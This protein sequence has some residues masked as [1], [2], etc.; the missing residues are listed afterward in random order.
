MTRTSTRPDRVALVLIYPCGKAQKP[1]FSSP[2][3]IPDRSSPSRVCPA[4]FRAL[5]GSGPIREMRCLRGERGVVGSG[6]KE[7]F[8]HT[9]LLA[10]AE[11]R[12]HPQGRSAI[13]IGGSLAAPPLPHHR[14]YGSVHG[15]STEF[16]GVRVRRAPCGLRSL[17]CRGSGLHPSPPAPRPAPTGCSAAWSA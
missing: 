13:G 15:G 8:G 10:A 3:M 6:R 7:P 4:A 16:P 5:D 11:G 12:C 17:W 14:A 1:P 9:G 2:W